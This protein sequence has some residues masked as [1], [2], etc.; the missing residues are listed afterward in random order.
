MPR[1]GLLAEMLLIGNSVGV[2]SQ[3]VSIVEVEKGKKKRPGEFRVD[4]LLVI[5]SLQHWDGFYQYSVLLANTP[6]WDG[7]Y[8][9][10]HWD[11]FYQYSV[12]LANTPHW[13]G[14]YQYLVL[15]ANTP[16]WDGFYQYS[17]PPMKTPVGGGHGFHQL[18]L[19]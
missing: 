14:F 17:L 19:S 5:T 13:D 6:H 16:H 2:F 4:T 8:Q 10:S 3:D 12:L 7:F 18:L 1:R 9:Y 15:L 11:G